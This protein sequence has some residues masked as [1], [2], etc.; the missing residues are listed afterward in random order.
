MGLFDA[1]AL[2]LTFF[3]SAGFAMSYC[4]ILV[5]SGVRRQRFELAV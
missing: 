2:A 3:A 1:A 5:T 4:R